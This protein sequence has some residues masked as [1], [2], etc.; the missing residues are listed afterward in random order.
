MSPPRAVPTL[1][2]YCLT[3]LLSALLLFCVQ[4]YFGRLLLPRFGGTPAVWNGCL[5]FYQGVLLLGYLYADRV[6]RI[7]RPGLALGLHLGTLLCGAL[8]LPPRLLAAWSPAGQ[9]NPIPVL[10]ALLGASLALPFLALSA[11]AP[12]LQR[13]FSRLGLPQSRD[14]YPLYAASNLGSMAGLLGYPVLLEPRLTLL[15]QSRLWSGLY[16]LFVLFVLLCGRPLLRAAAR[17]A[18][19]AR[20]ARALAA[21]PP[22]ARLQ[23]LLLSFVPASL[24]Y[25]TTTMISTDIAAVPLLWIVPLSLYLASFVLAFAQGDAPRLRGAL[26]AVLPAVLAAMVVSF[27]MNWS[28]PAWLLPALH[29]GGFFVAAYVLHKELASRRP[30]AEHLT[31]FYLWIAIG[32]LLAGVYNAVLAPSLYDAVVEYPLGLVLAGLL[33]QATAPR[34]GRAAAVQLVVRLAGLAAVLALLLAGFSAEGLVGAVPGAAVL[35]LL[36]ALTRRGFGL[37]SG[38]LAAALAAGLL[39]SQFRPG[40]E[41]LLHQERSFFGVHRIYE[42]ED[43]FHVYEHGTTLHGRQSLDPARRRVAL[44]YFA[45]TGPIGQLFSTFAFSDRLRS[46]AVL[47]LGAGTLATYSRASQA[48]DFYEIDPAVERIARDPRL[49]TFLADAPARC[50]VVLG[51]ARLSL[52]AASESYDLLVTDVFSSDAIPVHLFTREAFELYLERLAPSGLI[53]LHI[54]NRFLDLEPVVAAIAADLGLVG[55]R[56]WDEAIPAEEGRLGKSASHWVVLAR[57]EAE[58][59]RLAQDPRWSAMGSVRPARAWTDDYSDLWGVFRLR[60]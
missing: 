31:R 22:H 34:S 5:L 38:P 29:L 16:G 41:G 24:V 10:L 2:A 17:T 50:R 45:S 55:L 35:V 54:T 57:S 36:L 13:W 20:E 58:F 27:L 51:D 12:L 7:E 46:V 40:A 26:A 3:L 18:P 30:A 4:L 43:G 32:G 19:E 60:E 28:R 11:T 47:G 33:L 37:R 49:F 42:T 8:L 56:Q 25:G 44:A 23:W 9:E 39:L 53:A 59:G 48:W 21:P 1:L 14:P 15:E 6:G 52:A